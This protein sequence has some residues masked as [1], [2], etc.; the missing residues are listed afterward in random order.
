MAGSEIRL[1]IMGLALGVGLLV[2]DLTYRISLGLLYPMKKLRDVYLEFLIRRLV[3][4]ESYPLLF[5]VESRRR[6]EKPLWTLIS[7]LLR[8]E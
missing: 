4:W 1:S 2:V 8:T 5:E 6:M 7:R 3:A